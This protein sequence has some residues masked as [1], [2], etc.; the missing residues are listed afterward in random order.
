EYAILPFVGPSD[1]EL[2]LEHARIVRIAG[3]KF[4]LEDNNS[5]LGTSVNGTRIPGRT[6]LNDGDVIKLGSNSIRFSER[7][8]SRRAHPAT[9]A[10]PAPPAMAPP[11]APR[12]VPVAAPAPVPAP[13]TASATTQFDPPAA[14]R[15]PQPTVAAPPPRPAAPPPAPAP[16]G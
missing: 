9:A 6:V 1:K 10:V 5:R 11:P 4:A 7:H 2:N 8:R 15:S 13:A 3:G 12:P 14:R 16:P